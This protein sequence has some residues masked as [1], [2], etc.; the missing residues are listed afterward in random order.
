MKRIRQLT[1]LV[2]A[3]GTLIVPSVAHASPNAV[4]RDCADDGTLSGKYSKADLKGALK[5][6]PSDL[7]EYS[8]CRDVI[9]GAI[10]KGGGS[11]SGTGGSTTGGGGAATKG[12]AGSASAGGANASDTKALND[13][14]KGGAGSIGLNGK[15]IE[16][17]GNGLFNLA[18][19]ANGIPTPLMI[20]LIALALLAIAHSFVALRR[21]VPLLAKISAPSLSLGPLRRVSLPRF[22]R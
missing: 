6:I 18:N 20:T 14:R 12:G 8:D 21:R 3:M 17:R 15:K 13:A 1:I 2:A 22:R 19:A 7:D 4:L 5:R 10:P 16:P 11:G 9:A